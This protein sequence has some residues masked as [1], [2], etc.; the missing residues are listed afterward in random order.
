MHKKQPH[1]PRMRF[2]FSQKERSEMAHP[3]V[4]VHGLRTPVSIQKTHHRT[5]QADV[6]GVCPRQADIA[7]RSLDM[8]LVEDRSA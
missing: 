4:H 5:Q 7:T 1:M 2:P 6:E 8:E 3:T